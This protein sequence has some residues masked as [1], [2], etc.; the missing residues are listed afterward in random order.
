MSTDDDFQALMERV[1][2][3][4]N[5]WVAERLASKGWEAELVFYP[6]TSGLPTT[7]KRRLTLK[8]DGTYEISEYDQ[9]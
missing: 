3:A 5:R 7:I 4:E 2:R 6:S 9:K 8:P 1:R